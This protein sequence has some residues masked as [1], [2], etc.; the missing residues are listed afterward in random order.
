[1]NRQLDR[2]YGTYNLTCTATHI[3]NWNSRGVPFLRFHCIEILAVLLYIVRTALFHASNDTKHYVSAEDASIVAT[4]KTD[5][6]HP[7]M[8]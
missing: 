8:R 6:S 3:L 7:R 5:L 1:M 2:A 4:V